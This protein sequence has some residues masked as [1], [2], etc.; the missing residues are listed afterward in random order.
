M[1]VS[2]VRIALIALAGALGAVSRY[3][4]QGWINDAIGHPTLWATFVVNI[5]GAFALGMLVAVSEGRWNLS[6][7]TR[8]A[9]GIGFLGAY[10]TF[11][12][13]MFESVDRVET[14]DYVAAAAN[15]I[16][17]VTIGLIAA[18]AGLSAGRAI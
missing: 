2:L 6:P 15:I 13:L 12:T 4:A 11:S 5:S 17:S 9:L 16:G 3:K 1:E 7:L 10:T 18:Y 8:T 14:G